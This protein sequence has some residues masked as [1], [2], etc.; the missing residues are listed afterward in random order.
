MAGHSQSRQPFPRAKCSK[1]GKKG[2]GKEKSHFN[3][4]SKT[5]HYWRECRYCRHHAV[6]STVKA[7]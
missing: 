5:L 4:A 1:C 2:L 6:T 7:D 3:V